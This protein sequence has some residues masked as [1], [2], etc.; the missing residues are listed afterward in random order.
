MAVNSKHVK[1]MPKCKLLNK[2]HEQH[3]KHW[4]IQN[5]KLSVWNMLFFKNYDC[6]KVD[7]IY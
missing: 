3:F 6:Q 5:V 4:I 1:N 2:T 7:K